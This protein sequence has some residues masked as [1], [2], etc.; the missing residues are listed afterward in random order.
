MLESLF[1]CV[2]HALD[3]NRDS[4]ASKD[5]SHG[6]FFMKTDS[7]LAADGLN[8]G[9]DEEDRKADEEDGGEEKLEGGFCEVCHEL[10]LCLGNK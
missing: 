1:Y 3:D 6:S 10:L 4:V 9:V 2:L 5:G 7:S 8:G